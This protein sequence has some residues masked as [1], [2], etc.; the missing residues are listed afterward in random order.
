MYYDWQLFPYFQLTCL[1]SGI[2]GE[3]KERKVSSNMSIKSLRVQNTLHHW[4]SR[5]KDSNLYW[6]LSAQMFAS[7][8][9]LRDFEIFHEMIRSYKSFTKL[10][11]RSKSEWWKKDQWWSLINH[12]NQN[13]TSS[14]LCCKTH[15][16][17]NMTWCISLNWLKTMEKSFKLL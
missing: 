10:R 9:F 14:V 6:S 11:R 2:C 16:L 4:W 5:V 13:Q 15:R 1:S 8:T 12:W 3:R 17:A 7:G